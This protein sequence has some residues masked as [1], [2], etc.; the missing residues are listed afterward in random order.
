MT[1]R[2]D[3]QMA[4]DN[5]APVCQ[6]RNGL[7]NVTLFRLGVFENGAAVAM[8]YT[9][10]PCMRSKNVPKP[11]RSTVLPFPVRSYEN[12][13]ARHVGLVEVLGHAAWRAALSGNGDAVQ[14]EL[15]TLDRFAILR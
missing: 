2:H 9:S 11:P 10:L 7:P 14:I 3:R 8:L 15:R 6:L 4:E 5:A 1:L 13:T 12:P